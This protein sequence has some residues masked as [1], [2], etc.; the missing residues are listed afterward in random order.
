MVLG[1]SEAS[2]EPAILLYCAINN[3]CTMTKEWN[4]VLLIKS[5]EQ[6]KIK[7]SRNTLQTVMDA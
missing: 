4:Y 3:K 1:H 7:T 5:I 6:S 2:Q